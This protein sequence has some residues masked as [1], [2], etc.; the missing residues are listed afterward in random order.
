[1]SAVDDWPLTLEQ[2]E[3]MSHVAASWSATT[4]SDADKLAYWAERAGD[5]QIID[6]ARGRAARIIAAA[7]AD[8]TLSL[9][10]GHLERRPLLSGAEVVRVLQT[11]EPQ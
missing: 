4:R 9:L 1:V 6:R 10:A 8:G 3:A 7:A 11:K 2:M 5:P